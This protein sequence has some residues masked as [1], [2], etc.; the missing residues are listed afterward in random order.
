MPYKPK[1]LTWHRKRK[2]GLSLKGKRNSELRSKSRVHEWEMEKKK[3]TQ[4]H[5]DI[6]GKSVLPKKNS[7]VLSNAPWGGISSKAGYLGARKKR[8][9][10]EKWKGGGIP[11]STQKP[12]IFGQRNDT[13][14][15][16]DTTT[17]HTRRGGEIDH[18]LGWCQR[19]LTK[20]PTK[21]WVHLST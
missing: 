19:R 12:G 18:Q 9:G 4:N 20:R 1:T 10:I 5:T 13:N 15:D 14:G 7:K 16:I 3:K 2:T 21:G 11:E 17:Q 6:G 8:I